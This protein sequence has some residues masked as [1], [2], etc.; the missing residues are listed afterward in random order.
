MEAENCVSLFS[1]QVAMLPGLLEPGWASSPRGFGKGV[2]RGARLREDPSV[3]QRSGE[4]GHEETELG[5]Y[6]FRFSVF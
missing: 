2:G 6:S 1:Q 4:S 3:T 5:V